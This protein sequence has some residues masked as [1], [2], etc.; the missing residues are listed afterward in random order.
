[1][2]GEHK[3]VILLSSS[4]FLTRLEFYWDSSELQD[5][6]TLFLKAHS[7]VYIDFQYPSPLN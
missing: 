3:I 5:G 2:Q 7:H 1:L 6:Q 4:I